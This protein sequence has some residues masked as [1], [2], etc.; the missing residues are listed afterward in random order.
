MPLRSWSQLHTGA[1]RVPLHW[2]C[3]ALAQRKTMREVLAGDPPTPPRRD[4]DGGP[5]VPWGLQLTGGAG[6][7]TLVP[8]AP[9]GPPAPPPLLPGRICVGLPARWL[10][11]P[12]LNRSQARVV[13]RVLFRCCLESL[14]RS[15]QA[16][17]EKHARLAKRQLERGGAIALAR[18]GDVL[19][20]PGGE[21]CFLPLRCLKRLR[22]C[23]GSGEP[24]CSGSVCL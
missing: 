5:A 24:G 9:R 3:R 14:V 2:R 12:P 22:S 10:P 4:A 23:P 18:A 19:Q 8:T 1:A 20:L 13:L 15:Y 17:G 6:T 16:V 11:L 21:P 7:A